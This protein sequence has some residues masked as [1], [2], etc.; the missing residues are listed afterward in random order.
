MQ[1][2]VDRPASSGLD[3]IRGLRRAVLLVPVMAFAAGLRIWV[4]QVELPQCA[5]VTGEVAC[6]GRGISGYVASQ[7]ASIA[8]GS[9]Y[10]APGGVQG[11]RAGA[12]LPLLLAIGNLLGLEGADQL[13]LLTAVLGALGVGAVGLLAWTTTTRHP[14][15]TGLVA[16]GLAA[17]AP[18]LIA[19]DALAVPESALPLVVAAA[20]AAAF[21]LWWRD[22]WG[23]RAALGALLGLAVLVTGEMVVFAVVMVGALVVVGPWPGRRRL[24]VG[25]AVLAVTAAVVLPWA[26]FNLVRFDGAAPLG[27]EMGFALGASACDAAYNGPAAGGRAP[28][29]G[30][31]VVVASPGGARTADEEAAASS[32]A[33]SRAVQH[34]LDDV[35]AVPGVA[36][37]RVARL[38]GLASWDDAASYDELVEGTGPQLPVAG[39]WFWLA[40]VPLAVGGAVVRRRRGELLA[41]LLVGPVAATAWAVAA[42]ATT[43]GR[44]VAGVSMLV[45]GAAGAVA[46]GTWIWSRVGGRVP[47]LRFDARVA[48]GVTGVIALVVRLFVNVVVLPLCEP[49]TALVSKGDSCQLLFADT[50]YFR[51]Q[52]AAVSGGLAWPSSYGGPGAQHPP[53]FSLL[54]AMLDRVGLTSIQQHRVVLAFV[55]AVGVALVALAAASLVDGRARARVA[56]LT[57]LIAAVF[58]PMWMNDST[59]LS[60]TLLPPLIA[61]AVVVAV[62]AWRTPTV[63]RLVLVG[64]VVGLVALARSEALIVVPVYAVALAWRRGTGLGA[65]AGRAAV[66]VMATV[67]VCL[68]WVAFNLSRFDRPVTMTSTP[69]LTALYTACDPVVHG[70]RL[71]YHEF[72]CG[73]RL[74]T[75]SPWGDESAQ[76]AIAQEVVLSY[77]RENPGG[78]LLQAGASTARMLE[79][80]RPLE[81]LDL[82]TV[83]EQR[84]WAVSAGGLLWFWTLLP[85]AV[86]G[87][88]TVGR[89]RRLVLLAAWV[90]PSLAAVSIGGAVIRY[91]APAEVVLVVLAGIGLSRL[92][93]GRSRDPAEPSGE[94]DEDRAETDDVAD[95]ADGASAAVVAVPVAPVADDDLAALGAAPGTGSHEN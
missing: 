74:F 42:G 21:A 44:T 36:A 23:R 66:V 49:G 35:A 27:T 24:L 54:L 48:A 94:T 31:G 56:M 86:V 22:T 65:R 19:N 11:G 5:R 2:V 78:V 53:L 59:Y 77:Y 40:L 95:A 9:G 93:W 39:A 28:T 14:T 83:V 18:A 43:R 12:V 70:E 76:D 51:N 46:L 64:G 75:D 4:A 73:Q 88:V 26:A 29:C 15:A 84:G 82:A 90:L 80:Y 62:R 92:A 63:L 7:A 6:F 72:A 81:N 34:A 61:L 10:L 30:P 71:G 58:P 20:I 37:H 8:D 45:L 85:L 89:D 55:G 47:A 38:W 52:A 79:V 50:A 32:E 25:A 67:A 1:P 68:P 91:R 41:P 57:G 60:E 33:G 13:R 16:A 3:R 87:A 69:W 17:V